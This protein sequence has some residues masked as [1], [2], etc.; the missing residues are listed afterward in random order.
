MGKRKL[1]SD[2]QKDDKSQQEINDALSPA[3]STNYNEEPSSTSSTRKTRSSV[4]RRL[5]DALDFAN[6]SRSSDLDDENN[7]AQ[8]SDQSLNES[9]I[10]LQGKNPNKSFLETL[11]QKGSSKQNKS[12]KP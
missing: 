3:N 2:D 10:T 5:D 7:N 1:K 8:R 11:G 9:G 4:R 6:Q 12:L